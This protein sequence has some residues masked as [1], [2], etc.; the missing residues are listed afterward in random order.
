M[1]R[2][3]LSALETVKKLRRIEQQIA[4][5]KTLAAAC[6][7][8]GVG[9]RSYARWRTQYG[10]LA[11]RLS[12][13]ETRLEQSQRDLVQSLEQQRATSEILT[14]ISSSPT[15]VQ[16]VFDTIVAS[17]VRLCGGLF[18]ALFRY[19]GEW[20]H[21]VAQHNFTPEALAE[22][23]RVY[24]ARP[25][26]LHGSARAILERAVVHIPDVDLDPDY[27]H[28]DL[29][30]AVGLRSGLFVPMM[31]DGNPI[32]VLMVARAKAGRFSE[33]DIGLLQIFA[34]QA[35]IA[36]E[37]VRLFN[38]IESRNRQLT[39]ALEQQTATSEI[40]R[41]ISS[42]QTDVQPVFDAIVRSAV[43]LCDAE[44]S[45][46]ARFDGEFLHPLAFH[47]FSAKAL[48]I[49]KQTFPMRPTM[50][51]MV[52]RAALTRAVDNLA[53]MLADPEYAHDFA[54]A[55]GWRS[56]LAVPMLRDGNL[57]GAIAVSRSK[58]GAFP[59]QYVE[60]LKTF[61]DQAVIAIENVRLFKEIE[62]RNRDLTELLEQQTATSDILRVISRSQTDVQPVFDT[63]AA[64]S[65]RLC[66]ASAGLVFIFDGDLI[67][68]VAIA[69]L[70]PEGADAWR[71]SFP[72]P[73]SRDTA[74]TRAVL[75]CSIAAIPDV[76]QDADYKIGDT[77]ASTGFR[78]AVAVPLIREGKAIGVIGV[79]R[80]EPGPFPPEQIAL[81]QTFAD[82]G[83]IAIENVRLFKELEA[84][85]G[86]LT[87]SL[88]QQT[89]TAEVLKVIS[90][91]TF[92]LQPVLQ[93]LIENAAR[94]CSA[95]T[96][97]IF[98]PDADGNCRPA[99]QYQ[100]DSK[101]ELLAHMH[102]HP[103][104]ADRGSTTG[105]AMIERR[106][107]HIVDIHAD[108]EFTRTDISA[109][110]GYCTTL[111]VPMLRGDELIGVVGLMR[112]GAPDPFTEKQIELVTTFADQAVIA[113]EN[114]RLFTEIKARTEEL[115]RSVEELRVL[116]DVGRAVSSTLNLE[117]VL[118]T[119]IT[120]A[121]QLSDADGG[122]TIYE[123]DESSGVF[124][125]RANYGT[126][127]ATIAAQLDS[128][129][130]IGETTVGIAAKRRAP[131]QIADMQEEADNRIRE[132][133]W[134]EGIRAVLAVPLLRDER[135]IGALVIRRKTPGEFP[136]SV[137]DLLQTFAG[138][139]VL[140]I[141]NARLFREVQEKSA[142]VEIANRHK[143]EFLANMS[144]E[145]RTPL[146][147]VIG[148]SE[149]LQERM[150]G[151]LNDKQAEY[152]DD[153][154]A[155]G[156]HLLSL[157][158]DILDLSKVEA[159]RMELD[160]TTFSAPMAID[161]ALTLIR[162][163]AERHGIRMKC[164]IEPTIGDFNGDE[165]KFKQILLNLLS[166]A[167]KFTP[168]GGTIS[169]DARA[170]AGG[171]EV[172][173]SD[174][175]VGIAADDCAKVFEEFRQVGASSKKAEGTGLGLSLARKFVELHGGQI[176]VTSEPGKGSQF[177]FSFL[178]RLRQ[179]NGSAIIQTPGAG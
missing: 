94:L 150:F 143:S 151:E 169:V 16:P 39:V 110:G 154:H 80:S 102:E 11:R 51:N 9:T 65:L 30:R 115:S 73:P 147:A 158:N 32:G 82:Q 70:N 149:A 66:R 74:A 122:G 112:T 168:E 79:G 93:T 131:Y 109:M 156:K 155:S 166:N 19:D 46:A 61:A 113:I 177:V 4:R 40:L 165:R 17:V 42:A 1:A 175:G 18:S 50:E 127:S 68:L 132:L 135:I 81:L 54:L 34:D 178:D 144:H 27:T 118:L 13:L 64:A 107:V 120:H 129:I 83:V 57:I 137:L 126:S 139:S 60:L 134:R 157:I 8:A 138:Q 69:N 173:V 123:F 101:P 140:A 95:D 108:R 167:V 116:G 141:Q 47:G 12:T 14:V 55:G 176:Q 142:Q 146:N 43:Q 121:V 152:I 3:T 7:L 77:A 59:E 159:G 136:Q 85:N 63:I 2:K 90:R 21:Q 62:S 124:E 29:T 56:G 72:R 5:G 92:D 15:D 179:E 98:R 99:V 174:T 78:S 114:V 75:T 44:H 117:N 52:G 86:D 119:I 36:I 164:T 22:V 163:R 130:R 28:K 6:K 76:L 84:R 26:R 10:A 58:T 31:R 162:A 133:L 24:P 89:A 125:P 88:N 45:I 111:A 71:D 170:I 105:R 96:A 35:V 145:L 33:S 160:I 161:N 148:F 37:N 128:R 20:I 38:E 153:I 25:S 97:I 23:R 53:D 87:E 103:F 172:C 106:T 91:S 67:H 49:V 171:I 104:R 48:E 100:L 41:V